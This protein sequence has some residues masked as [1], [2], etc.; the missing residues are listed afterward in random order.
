MD[1]R[2]REVMK[3]GGGFGLLGL[4][5]GA[6]L[7]SPQVAR[8]AWDK[9]AFDSRGVEAVFAALGAGKPAPSTEIR[10]NAPEIAENGA[11]VAVSVVSNLPQTEQ[12]A[13]LV[14]RNPYT[15]AAH[16][17]IPPGTAADIQTRIKMAESA[18]VYAVVKAGGR[19]HV[20]RREVKVTLG[21]CG[22]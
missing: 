19:F 7:V 15:L 1:S 4:L 13:L 9:A 10:I 2:R 12:I 22:A 21:G 5:V 17:V 16:F 20:A 18:N 14:D 3:A 8:A 6:G 11:V